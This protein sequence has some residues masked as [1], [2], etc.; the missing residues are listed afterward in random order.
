MNWTPQISINI[1]YMFIHTVYPR[2]TS[3]CGSEVVF[4]QYLSK[5]Y[6]IQAV[7]SRYTHQ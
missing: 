1:M 3:A 7:A 4:T 6:W 2:S 5:D